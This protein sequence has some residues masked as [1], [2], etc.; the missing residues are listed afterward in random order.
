LKTAAP[1]DRGDPDNTTVTI[2]NEGCAEPRSRLFCFHLMR[3]NAG[4]MR[5]FARSEKL[6]FC[7]DWGFLGSGPNA[8]ASEMPTFYRAGL[9]KL[10]RFA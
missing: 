7:V 9:A 10:R 8:L 5:K 2:Q 1:A 4:R 6:F 3:R